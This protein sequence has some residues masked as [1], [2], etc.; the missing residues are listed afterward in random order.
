M[1]I[2]ASIV[3]TLK[4]KLAVVGTAPKAANRSENREVYDLYLRGN[5]HRGLITEAAFWQAMDC[6]DGALVLDPDYARAHTDRASGYTQLMAYGFLSAAQALPEAEAAANRAVELDDSLAE[7]HHALGR[8]HAWF[9]WDWAGAEQ[10]LLRALDL[11]PGDALT[12]AHYAT[13][14]LTTSARTEEAVAES[15]RAR[16]LDPLSV[17]INRIAGECLFWD[18]QYDETIG[19][20]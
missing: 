14:C 7:A 8:V 17:L 13:D 3:E 12:H 2:S 16:E 5:Y 11:V 1:E 18:R 19:L 15:R 6:Y 4:V 9:H 20:G 10:E